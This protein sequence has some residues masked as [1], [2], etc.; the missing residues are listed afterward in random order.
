[1]DKSATIRSGLEW[2]LLLLLMLPAVGGMILYGGVRLWM[3]V[4]FIL[5][6]YGVSV[7]LA[8]A[9]LIWRRP[10]PLRLPPGILGFGAF[11]L[12]LA[13]WLPRAPVP[14]E[15]W[16]ALF[17]GTTYLLAFVGITLLTAGQGR[18][19]IPVTILIAAGSLLS[20]YALVQHANGSTQVLFQDR[21][22]IYGMRASAT[23]M[24]PNHFAHV[25]SVILILAVGTFMTRRVGWP[26]R[27][28]CVYSVGVGLPVLLLTASR[29]AW[30]GLA[31]GLSVLA[32]LIGLRHSFRRFLAAIV[33]LVLLLTIVVGALYTFS[34]TFKDRVDE[35][36]H[37]NMRTQ[38]WADT[39]IAIGEEPWVGHGP[40]SF[41]WIYPHY[42]QKYRNAVAYPRYTHNEFLNIVSDY[43]GV[44]A[45]LLAL[46]FGVG[47]VRI[48]WPFFRGRT[49]EAEWFTAAVV[50]AWA[51]TAAHCMFDFNLH[52]FANAH[53]MA[54][55]TALLA[56]RLW[57]LGVW[58]AGNC[59]WGM[60]VLPCL[61]LI[62]LCVFLGFSAWMTHLSYLAAIEAERLRTQE[63]ALDEA[64][65][66]ADRGIAYRPNNW[67]AHGERANVFMTRAFWDRDTAERRRFGEA[68]AA[69]YREVLRLNRYELHSRYELSRVYGDALGDPESSLATLE[70]LV[71][72]VPMHFYYRTR[73]GL[74]LR[75]LGRDE[76]ALAVFWEAIELSPTDEMVKMNIR[77]LK[78]RLGIPLHQRRPPPTTPAAPATEDETNGRSP[79]SKPGDPGVG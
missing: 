32:G 11:I 57:A 15:A 53:L 18:W 75:R 17:K 44:G 21:P 66:Q 2:V 43:G 37:G 52:L 41:R 33:V 19:R 42:K 65:L 56:G 29:S 8:V 14:A 70:E 59:T 3:S 30:I 38:V 22:V 51:G 6:V 28:L 62:A 58:R 35:A 27:L 73:L 7:L 34:E 79:L 63:L 36:Q 46:A 48:L 4:P 16:L 72:F 5:V 1:M 64:L 60:R 39:C 45:G 49:R 50:G 61:G 68:A 74:R 71:A 76:E 13:W 25:L 47:A 20:L 67:R 55:V 9:V 12:Y 24:C 54:L 77:S 40:G 69:S 31:V 78:K 23:Y 26:L 10:L